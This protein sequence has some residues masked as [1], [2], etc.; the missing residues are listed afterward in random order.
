MTAAV[1]VLNAASAARYLAAFAS[2]R[3]LW[4]NA[5]PLDRMRH[6][7]KVGTVLVSCDMTE[8]ML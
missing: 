1:H 4:P 6:A 7:A 2:G 3:L 5:K 8:T